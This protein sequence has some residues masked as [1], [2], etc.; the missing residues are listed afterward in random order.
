M[1]EQKETSTATGFDAP[2]HA[3]IAAATGGVSPIGLSLAYTDWYLHLLFSPDKQIEL[4]TSLMTRA[5]T[6]PSTGL[7]RRSGPLGALP[8]M[9][10][11]EAGY[12]PLCDA[13]STY[14]LQT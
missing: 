14:V 11:P 4:A 7:V 3:A 10:A 5:A 1:A 6:M 13:P 8:A 12:A 9:G 2:F